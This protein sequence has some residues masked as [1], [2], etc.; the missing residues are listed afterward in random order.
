[1]LGFT[2]QQVRVSYYEGSSVY[3]SAPYTDA[4]ESAALMSQLAG[5]PVRLQF[6]RWDEHG[7]DNYGPAQMMDIR[8]G[9]DANGNIV[10]TDSTIFGIPYYTTN[11]PEAMTGV[12]QTFNGTPQVFGTKGSFDTTNTGTQYNLK[13]RRVIGKSLPLQN[14]YFKVTFLRAPNA[15]QTTFGYE[16]MIDELAHAANMDPY[17]FRLQNVATLASDEANGLTALTWDRWKN[18]LVRVGQLANWQP[19]VA[20]SNLGSG[21]IVTGRGIAFGS[22]AGTMVANVA[23]IQVN[24]K[25]GKITP[26]EFFSAQD[27]GFTVYPGGIANQAEGSLVQGASRALFE[28]VAFNKSQVTSLDWVTYPIMRFADAPKITFDY[29]QRTDIPA[30]N[31]GTLQA[32]GTTAP[33]TTVAASGVFASGSGEPP[34]ASIGAAMANALFDAT[35]VRLR[36]APM[37]PARVRAALKAGGVI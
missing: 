33:S 21:T 17:E 31:T 14:N 5:A 30:V 18:V 29:V 28:E 37:T 6:M 1:M 24:K 35:G 11:P 32:N 19:K 20:A 13:N 36:S 15:P 8:G 22:F 9:V 12:S 34:T 26:L 10:A 23:D 3:G 4:A 27:T 2:I 25:T 16:Q 7:W